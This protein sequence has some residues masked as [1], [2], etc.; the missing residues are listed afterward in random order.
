MPAHDLSRYRVLLFGA[1]GNGNLGDMYQAVAVRRHLLGI[2]LE[3][4]NIFAC[5]MLDFQE[6]P[7]PGE[8]KLCRRP[9]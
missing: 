3:D 8:R 4:R 1:F 2:G 5:S 6:Y 9:I 7:F